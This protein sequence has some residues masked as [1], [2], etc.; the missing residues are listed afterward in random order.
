MRFIKY[1]ITKG[2]SSSGT[3]AKP[4][5]T[6]QTPTV[7][8]SGVYSRMSEDEAAISELNRQ[9]AQLNDVAN[10]LESKYLRKD[11]SDSTDHILTMGTGRSFGFVSHQYDSS[12][13]GFAL[14]E[15]G[16][17]STSP[18]SALI[19]SGLGNGYSQID[20]KNVQ[21][22]EVI[23]NSETIYNQEVKVSCSSFITIKNTTQGAYALIDAGY[24]CGRNYQILE[25]ALYMRYDS[26]M[27]P[28]G[29]PPDSPTH[30]LGVELEKG[31]NYWV[32]PL[33]ANGRN[34][35]YHLTY[36]VKYNYIAPSGQITPVQ[37]I[38][39][40]IR[41]TN[42]TTTDFFGG[43]A[44]KL[45]ATPDYLQLTTNG[46]GIRITSQGIFRMDSQGNLTQ[47]L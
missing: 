41:G 3:G 38:N 4:T 31:V 27:Q 23:T 18:D 42:T 5:A 33:F 2:K 28:A 43:I 40:Y 39:A 24:S 45:E 30:S 17:A 19:L 11:R 25:E 37:P 12:G 6:V 16:T 47:L 36:V 21:L 35:S 9:I 20:C 10:G 44:N 29:A 14:T 13:I 15:T 8:L 22:D 34:T 32:I 46:A 1:N 26:E 7:D